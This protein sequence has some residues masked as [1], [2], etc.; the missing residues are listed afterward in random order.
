MTAFYALLIRPRNPIILFL[1]SISAL[2]LVMIN[3]FYPPTGDL[4][5]GLFET[6]P[7]LYAFRSL[8][9][10][11]GPL[12]ALS[13]SLLLGYS[14][15]Y[16]IGSISWPNVKGFS[17]RKISPKGLMVMTWTVIVILSL[18]IV[19]IPYFTGQVIY[20]GQNIIPSARVEVPQYYYQANDFL[21]NA[22]GDFRVLNLPYC[23]LGYA[24]YSWENGY[25][26]G[27]PCSSIF[28]KVV[29]VSE[30]GQ[31]NELL[32]NMANE[33]ANSSLYF[34]LGKMLS[35]MN[36]RYV[37]LHADANWAFIQGQSPPW[38]AAPKAN[39]SMYDAGL[40]NAGFNIAAS[41]GGLVLYE[42]PEWKEV[43]FLQVNQMLAV[44]GGIPA[45]W[46]LTEES[47][48]DVSKMA[49][50][51]VHDLGD[52]ANLTF[53]VD[54]IY[55][56][57]MLFREGSW[58]TQE[59]VALNDS[60][61]SSTRHEL[62]VEQGQQ[63]L[64]FSERYDPEWAMSTGNGTADHIS[65][66]MFFNGYVIGNGTTTVTIEYQPQKM[67]TNL[68]TFSVL[69]TIGLFGF[70]SYRHLRRVKVR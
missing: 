35:I 69:L 49:F 19:A 55:Y 29:I 37:M 23:Q 54:G 63:Y 30:P 62:A 68:V 11:F 45:V 53:H 12:L 22:T 50:V 1:G 42:N 8:Y 57:H 26:G 10:H 39:F 64:I 60:A 16:L 21:N 25:W 6:F 4:L 31:S 59:G 65:V 36:V 18:S 33:I 14:M 40:R 15:A 27:D 7:I 44:V 66:N 70:L 43:H 41:F 34:N 52:V 20:E 2:S 24:A 13:Y 56:G 67:F 9:Q 58:K 46:N 3:G 51:V 48:Y 38:W 28:D 32:V 17:F 61:G 47:W 5:T